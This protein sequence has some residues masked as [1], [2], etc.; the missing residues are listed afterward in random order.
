MQVIYLCQRQSWEQNTG[1]PAPILAVFPIYHSSFHSQKGKD[2]L[3]SRVLGA[4]IHNL[5]LEALLL[6]ILPWKQ[7]EGTDLRDL[8]AVFPQ[9]FTI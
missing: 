8:T 1:I 7:A 3:T 5:H 4:F 9:D 6:A 2:F